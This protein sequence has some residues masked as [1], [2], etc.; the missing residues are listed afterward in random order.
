M[1]SPALTPACPPGV[2]DGRDDRQAAV[3]QADLD[4]DAPK[5]P[6]VL[7]ASLEF[8]L[9]QEARM[10]VELRSMPTMAPSMIRPGDVFDVV[11]L[12]QVHDLAE[13]LERG[14]AVFLRRRAQRAGWRRQ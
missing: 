14:E 4:A 7:P 11:V 13:A 12:H 6:E 8:L 5:S 10:G 2:V 1:M 9:G 3:L